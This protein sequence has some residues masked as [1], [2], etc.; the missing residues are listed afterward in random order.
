MRSISWGLVLACA[1]CVQSSSI[2]CPS[3]LT[4][5]IGTTCRIAHDTEWCAT[6]AQ[7]DACEDVPDRTAC[8]FSGAAGTCFDGVC[9]PAAC[10]NHRIDA[11]EACD[12]QEHCSADCLSDGSCGN[13][14]VDGARGEQCDDGNLASND[15]CSSRCRIETPF[16]E[17][18]ESA[19]PDARVGAAL[20]YDAA[21]DR[22]V[23]FGGRKSE[24]TGPRDLNDQWQWNGRGWARVVTPFAPPARSFHAMA[25][26][27]AAGV[28]VMFG[29]V[30]VSLPGI[31]G[32]PPPYGDTWQWDGRLW[33]Q[34]APSDAALAR[35]EQAMAYDAGR[36]RVIMYGGRPMSG[37]AEPPPHDD[38]WEWSG[39]E[40]TSLCKPCEPGGRRHAAMAYDPARG[41][42]VLFGGR[43]EE[44]VFGDT[45]ELANGTWARRTPSLPSPAGRRGAWMAYDAGSGKLLLGGGEDDRGRTLADVWSWDGQQWHEEA[46]TRVPSFGAAAASDPQRGQVIVFGGAQDGKLG[47]ETA[48]WD[49]TWDTFTP[50]PPLLR[51]LAVAGYDPL[52]GR[53]LVFGGQLSSQSVLAEAREHDGEHWIGVSAD[54]APPERRACAMTYDE[55]RRE[56]VMFGGEI[57]SFMKRSDTWTWRDRSWTERATGSARSYHAMAYDGIGVLSFGGNLNQADDQTARWDGTTWTELVPPAAP[58]PRAGHVMAFDPIRGKIVLFGGS[59]GVT[60]ALAADTWEWDAST[61]TWTEVTTSPRPPPRREGAMAW[62]PWRRRIVLFGGQSGALSLDDTWEFDGTSWQQLVLASRPPARS[63]HVLVVTPGGL[64]ASGGQAGSTYFDDVWRLRWDTFAR[65]ENCI[66]G[67]DGD[68]DG[69]AG[70]EDD[71]CWLACRPL[72]PP[73][74]ACPMDAPH[75]GDGVCGAV[76]SCRSCPGDCGPCERCGD[77]I[78]DGAEDQAS[79]PGDCTP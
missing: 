62:D 33:S 14:V 11:N 63:R 34:V 22:V 31:G 32:G 28:I 71:D 10:G 67:H 23:L 55:G 25:Y 27:A 73:G 40:W 24:E 15:G 56:L 59:V 69:L 3:G 61:S 75:C 66:A 5:P 79:C 58:A 4:C 52:A 50:L 39:A 6:Q 70:C 9:L 44:G 26:D 38:A 43:N 41:V 53:A 30:D 29:G 78:C 21:R 12:G 17:R 64:S 2:T 7:L 49:G 57:S 76:E 46:E 36:K 42:I 60:Q 74:T 18:V 16:W 1:G 51:S 19:I 45:W 47:A 20:A 48:L 68:G 77:A 65:G 72:C 54:P 13:G 35:S 37:F 8:S